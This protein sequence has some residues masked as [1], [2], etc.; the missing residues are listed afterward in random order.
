MSMTMGAERA[1][2]P[3]TGRGLR[4]STEPE[5]PPPSFY[6]FRVRAATSAG[7]SAYSNE[8]SATTLVAPGLCD[9]S[10]TALCLQ[11]DRFQVKVTW[12][13]YQ[14]NTGSGTGIEYT[15]DS[16][17]FWF[18]QST[19]IEFLIKVLNSFGVN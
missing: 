7:N 1:S 11:S 5:S 4:S 2:T 16:G 13:D 14:S 15:T 12:R 19:N 17:L 9:G 10:A 6:A 18:F 3:M 8:A